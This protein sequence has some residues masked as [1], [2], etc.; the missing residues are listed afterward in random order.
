MLESTPWKILAEN[1]GAP[2]SQACSMTR[3]VEQKLARS[4]NMGVSCFRGPPTQKMV[5]LLL[6]SL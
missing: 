4:P 3:I 6:A 2:N 1:T 5:V